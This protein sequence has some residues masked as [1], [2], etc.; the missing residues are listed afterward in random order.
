MRKKVI[1]HIEGGGD[2]KTSKQILRRGF[3]KF[4]GRFKTGQGKEMH[5]STPCWGSID[6]TFKKFR[7]AVFENPDAYNLLLVDSDA[8][9]VAE[10][11]D[12]LPYEFDGIDPSTIH[13]M[14]QAMEAWFMVDKDA[15]KKYYGPDFKENN[16][17]QRTNVEEIP[18]DELKPSI[19]AAARSTTKGDYREIR[20]GSRILELLDREKVKQT[21]H[22]KR[23]FDKLEE[24]YSSM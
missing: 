16:L 22:G 20:D 12:H 10:P 11:V 24:I 19:T 8:Q 7:S 4:I 18:K 15:L 3:S 2:K 14:V 23:F 17:P 9:V 1:V 13:L 6:E 5:P 21:T